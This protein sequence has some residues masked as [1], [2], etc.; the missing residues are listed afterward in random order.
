MSRLR[1]Q[2]KKIE[3]IIY[4][5]TPILEKCKR[6]TALITKKLNAKLG[7]SST[8]LATPLG[9]IPFECSPWP[10]HLP[11]VSVIVPCF[12]YGHFIDSA[13]QS[14]YNQTFQNF[15]VIVVD[16]SDDPKSREIV[17]KLSHPKLSVYLRDGRHLLGDNRNFGIQLARGKYVCCLDPDD[18]FKPTYLEKAL[19][20]L[21]STGADIVAPSVQTFGASSFTWRLRAKPNLNEHLESNKI[22]V[23]ALYKKE[24]WERAGGFFDFGLGASHIPED[25]DFWVR[26]MALG[27]R[28]R[29]ITEALMLYQ[30][31]SESMSAHPEIPAKDIQ[32]ASIIKHNRKYLTKFAYRRS[33]LIQELEYLSN[34]PELNLLG[35]IR[36]SDTPRVLL[37]LPF[38]VVGGS[39][40]R[41][42]K[43]GQ[44]LKKQGFEISIITSIESAAYQG[45]MTH[46]FA[47]LTDE[48]YPL[49]HLLERIEIWKSFVF[50]L[51][52]SRNI[53]HL[54]IG[55]SQYMYDLLPELKR[56]F[57]KLKIIDQHFNTEGHTHNF[58]K[59]ANYIDHTVAENEF[60]YD[61]LKK[62]HNLSDE[63]ISLIHNGIELSE[64]PPQNPVDTSRPRDLI[65]ISYIGRLSSEKGPELFV[66]IARELSKNPKFKFVLAGPGPM[67]TKL[68][69]VVSTYQLDHCLDMPGNISPPDLLRHTDILIVPSRIDGRP[70]IILEAM[71]AGVPVIASNVGGIPS[72][73]QHGQNGLLCEAGNIADFITAIHKLADNIELRKE[74]VIEALDYIRTKANDAVLLR[75]YEPIFADLPLDAH[76]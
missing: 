22:S 75:K 31:H 1:S 6:I 24:I 9:F 56:T 26:A 68:K 5:N 49:P 18:L 40:Q 45:D 69:N 13:L 42:L 4:S 34:H 15:E 41:H 74:I 38:L 70:N 17:S 35:T 37:A 2:V 62:E 16:C 55:N 7:T 66:E 28:V 10:K 3:G 59:Y 32:R 51:L 76:E 25:W 54:V 50:Y 65:T 27:A 39:Q 57:P 58:K 20:V 12:N 30:R 52:K 8:K 64:S 21:E 46:A 23:V 47:E 63:S 72:M 61:F 43:L 71:A 36:R 44:H 48:I 29:N 19:F 53:T 33:R 11:L 73:I 60:V 67:F 14:I